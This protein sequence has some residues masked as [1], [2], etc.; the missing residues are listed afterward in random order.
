MTV[1]HLRPPIDDNAKD[2]VVALHCSLGSG[3]QWAELIEACEGK[4]N[5]VAPDISGY[6]GN[7]PCSDPAP[8]KLDTEVEQLSEQLKTLSGPIHLVGH[9]FGG[10]LAFKLAV[11]GRYAHRVRSLT[12]IDP[13]LPA[14]LLEHE[15]DRSLYE[16][17][18][19]G[20]AHI[21]APLWSGDR[22]LT[23]QRFLTFWNGARS[24]K[25]LSPSKKAALLD[26][27]SKLA[28][29]YSAIFDETGVCVAARRLMVPTLLLSG[30]KSPL[31]T[32]QIA[33]R[34]ASMMPH[35]R[36]MHLPTAGHMLPVT[37][38]SEINVQILQLI[39]VAQSKSGV[40]P[41]LRAR[42]GA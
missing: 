10:A 33:R 23:L 7:S 14:I 38:A 8:S 27:V 18:A 17:F 16:L 24:W 42:A 15:A 32:Q 19:R 20:A 37:H 26:R 5:I 35:A 31:P 22:E 29:D 21:C 9:S 41:S 4:Y 30:G 3:E 2:N 40:A 34:L 12:L 25:S 13:A 39:D 1:I 6:G 28:A 36:H 11:N